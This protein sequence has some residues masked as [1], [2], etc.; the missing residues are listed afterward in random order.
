MKQ[1]EKFKF[2]LFPLLYNQV[3]G[4]AK[5]RNKTCSVDGFIIS[6]KISLGFGITM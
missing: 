1:L 2:V 6:L 4:F 3:N 5:A